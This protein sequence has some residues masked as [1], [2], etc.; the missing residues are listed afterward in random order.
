MRSC[1]GSVHIFRN[2]TR[3]QAWAFGLVRRFGNATGSWPFLPS[4]AS[5]HHLHWYFLS[6][7]VPS[8]WITRAPH[9]GCTRGCGLSW[10]SSRIQLRLE[11]WRHYSV[12]ANFLPILLELTTKLAAK[13]GMCKIVQTSRFGSV[14]TR[15]EGEANDGARRRL[16]AKTQS[17]SGSKNSTLQEIR[18]KSE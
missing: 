5:P 2:F 4:F 13:W 3:I 15:R 6:F 17:S 14:K 18:K 10:N 12:L 9:G 8:T 11:R 16:E 1:P 7:T